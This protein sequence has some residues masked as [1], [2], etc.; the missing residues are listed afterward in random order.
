MSDRKT[1]DTQGHPTA[2]QSA[3]Q[4]GERYGVSRR[5]VIGW[6]HDGIIPAAI[7]V[8]RVLRFDPS[9]V[10]QALKLATHD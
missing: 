10:D 1:L 3:S 7:H 4:L 8:G 2:Y 6:Y 5:T 9:A